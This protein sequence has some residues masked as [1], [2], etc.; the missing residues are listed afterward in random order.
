MSMTS[1]TSGTRRLL[2]TAALR[3]MAT[4]GRIPVREPV[5]LF[6]SRFSLAFKGFSGDIP[7]DLTCLRRPVTCT[8]RGQSSV[9]HPVGIQRSRCPTRWVIAAY[10]ARYSGLELDGSEPGLISSS[11]ARQRNTGQDSAASRGSK[12]EIPDSPRP[13]SGA[14]RMSQEICLNCERRTAGLS[15][16]QAEDAV[17]PLLNQVARRRSF[18][19][20][21]NGCRHSCLR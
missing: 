20:G 7:I 4:P 14:V 2:R 8:P 17:D 9:P 21:G 15:N 12:T 6:I 19:L 5:V 3:M 10:G 18:I 13:A 11:S 16:S 1:R